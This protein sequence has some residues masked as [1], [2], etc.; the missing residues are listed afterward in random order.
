MSETVEITAK[1]TDYRPNAMSDE[2]NSGGFAVYDA[3]ILEVISPAEKAGSVLPIYHNQPPPNDSVWRA[4]GA[5]ICFR[6]D[7]R[8]MEGGYL[9]FSAAAKDVTRL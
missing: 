9:L 4:A 1:V 5:R 8:L 6:I 3:T 7:K 2:Y